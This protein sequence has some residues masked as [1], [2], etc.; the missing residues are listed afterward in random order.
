MK[1]PVTLSI[2]SI[3][4]MAFLYATV[5][6]DSGL[7]TLDSLKDKYEAVQFD[8]SKHTGLAAD[9]GTCH[10]EHGGN[11]STCTDCHS[12]DKAVFQNAVTRSFTACKNCHDAISPDN[13]GMPGLKA[14]YHRVC[15]ECHRGMGNV[16]TDPAGCTEMCHAKI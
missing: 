3:L 14:A 6:A 16:G 2:L 12:L 8:H 1:I 7:V 10:H 15:F 5:T 13:P 4:L 11:R 9:C